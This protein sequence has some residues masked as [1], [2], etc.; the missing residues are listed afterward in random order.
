MTPSGTR[1]A[2]LSSKAGLGMYFVA[3][4]AKSENPP[5]TAIPNPVQ[6]QANR[7]FESCAAVPRL[8]PSPSRRK[9]SD[10]LVPNQS[11]SPEKCVACTKGYTHVEP[12]IHM[13]HEVP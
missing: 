5:R 11:E 10:K 6:F 13:A 12:L 3:A 1:M 9:S 8:L 4:L 2:S 7:A